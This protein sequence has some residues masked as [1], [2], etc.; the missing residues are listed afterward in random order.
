[1]GKEIAMT[2][3]KVQ[4]SRREFIRRAAYVPPVILT[5]AAAPSYAQTGSGN[6]PPPGPPKGKEKGKGKG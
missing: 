1:L 5:L 2:E 3:K 4:V 6:G